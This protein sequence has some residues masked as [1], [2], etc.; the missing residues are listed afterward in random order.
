MSRGMAPRILDSL[1]VC[2]YL[3]SIASAASV[4]PLAQYDSLIHP[5]PDSRVWQPPSP[6]AAREVLSRFQL[7]VCPCPRSQGSSS[8]SALSVDDENAPRLMERGSL[9]GISA[10]WSLGVERLAAANRPEFYRIC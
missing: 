10:L 4:P 7:C 5:W 9:C 1:P 8:S 2:V 6:I 3:A